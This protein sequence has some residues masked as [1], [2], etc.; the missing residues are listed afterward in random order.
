MKSV[1]LLTSMANNAAL[2]K[3]KQRPKQTNSHFSA[4]LE[5]SFNNSTITLGAVSFE[6]FII[7]FFFNAVYLFIVDCMAHKLL[8]CRLFKVII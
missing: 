7:A 8:S 4:I 5:T 6:R 3:R 2:Q 1:V